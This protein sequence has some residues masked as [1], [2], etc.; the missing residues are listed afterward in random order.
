MQE[1]S[2]LL[3]VKVCITSTLPLFPTLPFFLS[4]FLSLSNSNQDL[5]SIFARVKRRAHIP[6]ANDENADPNI[7]QHVGN[8]AQCNSR[9][10]DQ[11]DKEKHFATSSCPVERSPIRIRVALSPRKANGQGKPYTVPRMSCASLGRCL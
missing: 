8:N 3:K 10:M 11:M 7:I 4:F 9:G 2:T 5:S 6:V 1:L